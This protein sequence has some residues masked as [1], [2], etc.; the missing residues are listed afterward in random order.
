MTKIICIECELIHINCVHMEFTLSQFE[1]KVN[2]V[3][4]PTEEVA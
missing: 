2:S 3:N 4:Q 1:L